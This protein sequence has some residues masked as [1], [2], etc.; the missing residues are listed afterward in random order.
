MKTKK[1]SL[2]VVAVLLALSVMLGGCSEK[3]VPDTIR[4]IN[5]SYAVLTSINGNDYNLFGGM[6]PDTLNTK[7]QQTSLENWWGVTDRQTADE[8]LEWILTEGHRADYA[9][10]MAYLD[11]L[12]LSEIP[13]EEFA[14]TLPYLYE[15]TEDEAAEIAKFYGWYQ[16]IGANAIDGWDYCRALNL[17][18]FYY[19]A[20]YY[21]REEALDKSLEIALE[22]QP[23]F[24]SWDELIDSYLR[25]YEYWNGDNTD[26][27]ERR[28]VYESL[29]SAK[30]NPYSVDYHTTLQKE[31]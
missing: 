10:Y 7:L 1:K 27:T 2:I 13:L 24:D 8:T 15:L 6:K 9:D 20:G 21:T 18:S 30:D 17:L 22:V 3:K 12:G 14:E 11:E 16:E 4:W 31:W 5:A 25:G 23:L 26:S 19:V 29:L 28:Q